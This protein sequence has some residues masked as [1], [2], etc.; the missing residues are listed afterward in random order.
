MNYLD[1][2]RKNANCSDCSWAEQILRAAA[3]FIAE[4]NEFLACRSLDELSDCVFWWTLLVEEFDCPPDYHPEFEPIKILD[5]IEKL[6]RVR[7]LA[8]S[9]HET[10]KLV[11][12]ISKQLSGFYWNYIHPSEYSLGE[13][14]DY[15]RKKL[16]ESYTRAKK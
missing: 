3:G 13:I 16:T 14:Q 8:P 2:V 15:N 11:M 10:D 12:T 4:Y 6:T 7:N 5:A 1:F 9:T